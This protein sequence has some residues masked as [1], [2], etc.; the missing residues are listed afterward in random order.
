MEASVNRTK[1]S[2]PASQLV[3]LE[4]THREMHDVIDALLKAIEFDRL[5]FR[6]IA[7]PKLRL[8]PPRVAKELGVSPDK[9][10]GWIR[11]GELKTINVA[12]DQRK[13]PRYVI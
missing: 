8:T 1:I 5:H 9:V 3:K 2:L 11:C 12:A 7:E 13:R 10:L 4:L 6:S